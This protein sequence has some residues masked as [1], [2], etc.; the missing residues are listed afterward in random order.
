MREQLIQLAQ[1]LIEVLR[2]SGKRSLVT[3]IQVPGLGAQ[4]VSIGWLDGNI[5]LMWRGTRVIASTE[6]LPRALNDVVRALGPTANEATRELNQLLHLP[7][8]A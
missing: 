6:Q 7:R 5:E 1:D 4:T 8:A 2:T 3:V